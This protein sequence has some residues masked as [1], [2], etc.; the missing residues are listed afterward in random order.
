MPGELVPLRHDKQELSLA[1]PREVTELLTPVI[2]G[3]K[4]VHPFSIEALSDEIAARDPLHINVLSESIPHKFG[5]EHLMFLGASGSGKTTCINQVLSD[6]LSHVGKG[7]G[8]RVFIWDFKRTARRYLAKLPV[9]GPVYF[10]DPADERS[11]GIDWAR[12]LDTAFAAKQFSKLVVHAEA[13]RAGHNFVFT[14]NARSV[15][16]RVIRTFQRFARGKWDMPDVVEGVS[17]EENLQRVMNRTPK[18]KAKLKTILSAKGQKA[19][20]FF[21][22]E[23]FVSDFGPIAH[24]LAKIPRERRITL[25]DFLKT[26]SVL[27]LGH[28]E[29][30]DEALSPFQ[31]W[32]FGALTRELL[33]GPDIPHDGTTRTSFFLDEVRYSPFTPKDLTK[34]ANSGRSKG[35][36][37]VT[38]L[39]DIAGIR[40]AIGEAKAEEFMNMHKTKVFLRLEGPAAQW[41]SEKCFGKHLRMIRKFSEGESVARAYGI[42]ETQYAGNPP[43]TATSDTRTQTPSRTY[44]YEPVERPVI[45]P[46]DLQQLPSPRFEGDSGLVVRAYMSVEGNAWKE[47]GTH[48]EEASLVVDEEVK[49]I[50]PRDEEDFDDDVIEWE[51]EDFRR[52]GLIREKEEGPASEAGGMTPFEE[53]FSGA[54]DRGEP[55]EDEEDSQNLL[56]W[57]FEDE[58]EDLRQ[59]GEI[60]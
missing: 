2:R 5:Y 39:G 42:T 47:V 24:A 37:I 49:D 3:L 36:V 9:R 34:L 6:M 11:H 53:T 23:E 22:L 50:E 14:A 16:Y 45:Y 57:L 54:V 18:G 55:E 15:L 28:Y 27:V 8:H 21:S 52:L 4:L 19:G 13:D 38:G 43:S 20:V 40:D 17:S 58:L 1:R 12:E 31:R 41:V 10:L 48:M 30:Y 26:E 35:G 7:L 59:E 56:S 44:N 51:M 60:G 29:R 33:S 32:V 25:D 46:G